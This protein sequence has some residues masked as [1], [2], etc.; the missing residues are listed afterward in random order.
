MPIILDLVLDVSVRA[1]EGA[2]V[3]I[4]LPGVDGP[5]VEGGVIGEDIGAVSAEL[6]LVLKPSLGLVG[7]LSCFQRKPKAQ[8]PVD[9]GYDDLGIA[10]RVVLVDTD[11][12]QKSRGGDTGVESEL[13][14]R[15]ELVDED[16]GL[17]RLVS[18]VQPGAACVNVPADGFGVR[19]QGVGV[20]SDALLGS[21]GI[22]GDRGAARQRCGVF[23]AIDVD[24][25][26]V[27][28]RHVVR[29]DIDIQGTFDVV[30]ACDGLVK[31]TGIAPI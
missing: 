3:F 29:V 30:L 14:A 2:G 27:R 24:F 10:V 16:N 1:F 17:P 23:L 5:R 22:R 18:L 4:D 11:G 8:V 31:G 19:R 26:R 20:L 7:V 6:S 25:S 15:A 13:L 28:A 12:L 9:P 21:V